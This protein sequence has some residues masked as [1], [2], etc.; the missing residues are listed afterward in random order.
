MFGTDK[1]DL[2]PEGTFTHNFDPWAME[3]RW[4]KVPFADR[5]TTDCPGRPPL[6]PAPVERR[7]RVYI[8]GPL[9]TSGNPYLNVRKG[10]MAGTTLL[11]RGYAPY[12]PHLT[13][14][15]EMGAH[16]EF[17]YEDWMALDLA[18]LEVCDCLLRLDGASNGADREVAKMRELR[19]EVYYSMDS[20]CHAEPATRVVRP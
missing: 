9:L 17:K 16:E 18:Y 14:M 7:T 11:K 6:W 3:C 10:I 15:W 13:C 12:V 1:I 5:G 4:C 8:A 2:L 20:L 19:R